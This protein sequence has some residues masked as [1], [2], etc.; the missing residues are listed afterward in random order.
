MCSN[1]VTVSMP[2]FSFYSLCAF[3]WTWKTHFPRLHCC[4]QGSPQLS[5]PW[6]KMGQSSPYFTPLCSEFVCPSWLAGPPDV[7]Q[8]PL[9]KLLFKTLG[10]HFRSKAFSQDHHGNHMPILLATSTKIH[11][12]PTNIVIGWLAG[13]AL[14]RLTMHMWQLVFSRRVQDSSHQVIQDFILKGELLQHLLHHCTVEALDLTVKQ[15]TNIIA[16]VISVI[17]MIIIINS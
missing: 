5:G 8:P 9:H 11:T 14:R 12:S 15:R 10:V 16:L 2:L 3:T 17:I 4:V 13:T 1:A 6:T 7:F